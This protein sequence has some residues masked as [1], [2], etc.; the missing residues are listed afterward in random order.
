MKKGR[1]WTWSAWAGRLPV[2]P[3][4]N[5]ATA[6]VLA[7]ALFLCLLTLALLMRQLAPTP[8]ELDERPMLLARR[9]AAAEVFAHLY[10]FDCEQAAQAAIAPGLR[11]LAGKTGLYQTEAFEPALVCLDARLSRAGLASV[12]VHLRANRLVEPL[13]DL[14]CVGDMRHGDLCQKAFIYA[15]R[16]GRAIGLALSEKLGNAENG[17]AAP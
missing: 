12:E 9:A 1:Q 15:K 10:L 2:G 3:R 16:R 6:S 13:L 14:E 7:A 8:A 4:G 5:Y 17:L 11:D